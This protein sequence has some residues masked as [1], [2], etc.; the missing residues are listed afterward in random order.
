[1]TQASMLHLSKNSKFEEEKI[2]HALKLLHTTSPSLLLLA[3]LDAARANLTSSIGQGMLNNAIENALYFRAEAEKIDKLSV[4]SNL[5]TDI[6][7]N[8][9]KMKGL[10]GLQLEYILEHDY[11]ISLMQMVAGGLKNRYKELGV[12]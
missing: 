5:E 4:L 10:T 3:S 9:I 11:E 1:M 8:F 6:T 7:K 12:I 2:R